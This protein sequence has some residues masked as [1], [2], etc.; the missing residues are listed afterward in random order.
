MFGCDVLTVKQGYPNLTLDDG[1][2]NVKIAKKW[3]E[4]V[5]NGWT[6][7]KKEQHK[8]QDFDGQNRKKMQKLE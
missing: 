1:F 3:W 6:A 7:S 4:N 5:K 8:I 2:R